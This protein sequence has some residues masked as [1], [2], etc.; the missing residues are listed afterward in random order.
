MI[1]LCR[2]YRNWDQFDQSLELWPYLTL[3]RFR[4]MIF[5]KSPEAFSTSGRKALAGSPIRSSFSA[6]RTSCKRNPLLDNTVPRR[7]CTCSSASR[8]VY[9]SRCTNQQTT[10]QADLLCPAWQFTSTFRC[11]ARHFSRNRSH[12]GHEMSTML[13]NS[14]SSESASE[15]STSCCPKSDTRSVPSGNRA[16]NS[17]Q[18]QPK[19]DDRLMNLR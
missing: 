10:M 19:K 15:Y 2:W 6:K 14:R 4:L 17:H 12:E 16:C 13:K 11:S 18:P 1:E 9:P 5:P 7:P 3:R 8:R